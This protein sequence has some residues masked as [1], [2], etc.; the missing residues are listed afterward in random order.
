MS[1]AMVRNPVIYDSDVEQE[2]ESIVALLH[3]DYGI[4]K[5]AI[6]LLLLQRDAEIEQLVREREG[7]RYPLIA[8]IVAKAQVEHGRSPLYRIAITR[9][10][11]ASEIIE[12]AVSERPREGMDLREHLG[13]LLMH[14]IWGGLFLCLVLYFG[15]YLFVGKFGAGVAVDFFEEVVFGNYIIPPVERFFQW[16]IPWEWLSDLFIGE[17]G[18]FTLGVRYAIAIIL[19]IVTT[20]FIVFSIIEDTGYLPRLASL[21]DRFCRSLGLNG[22]A[23]IPLT[24]GFGCDTM[25]TIVTRTLETRRERILATFLLMLAI[26]CSAQLGIIVA[27]LSQRPLGLV[28]WMVVIAIIFFSVGYATNRLLPG[29]PPSF[30]MEVPPLRL[31]VFRNII[32]KTLA[33]LQ[34]YLM[35]V[36]PLFIL[37][38]A[39]IWVGRLTR[40]FDVIIGILSYPVIWIGLPKDTAVAFLFGFFRRDYGAAGIKDLMD[41]GML[42]GNDLVVSAVV[43]TL[44]V[45]CIAQLLIAIRE[46]GWRVATAMSAFI[47]VFAFIIGYIVRTLLA[48]A[49]IMI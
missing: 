26:P 37:A 16:L 41:K 12:R 14:P 44:F 35:E 8:R 39:L 48:L 27:M 18:I 13:N 21:M 24:L 19:P 2:I 23:V 32:K 17:Y 22:R 9:Q 38:S 3:A 6:A 47:F 30:Y 25:A 36:I 11:V 49:G 15:L 46:H 7:E 1:Q 33:R 42:T 20:F 4:A 10:S 34:W 29:T 5:R 43:I 45:P 31:P 40:I 28:I